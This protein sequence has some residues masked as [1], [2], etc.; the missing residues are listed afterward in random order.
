[1]LTKRL[2]MIPVETVVRNIVA[3]SMAKRLGREEG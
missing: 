3:G 2:E 1:M